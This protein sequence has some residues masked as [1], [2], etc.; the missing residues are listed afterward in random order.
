MTKKTSEGAVPVQEIQTPTVIPVRHFMR[1]AFLLGLVLICIVVGI[2]FHRLNNPIYPNQAVSQVQGSKP[3]SVPVKKSEKPVRVKL[4]RPIREASMIDELPPTQPADP[5]INRSPATIEPL[6][7]AI[8]TVQSKNEAPLSLI[9]ALQLRDKLAM[10][11]SC[12][13]DVESLLNA[14]TATAQPLLEKLIPVCVQNDFWKTLEKTFQRDKQEA[15][16]TYY[17]LN[18]PMWLAYIKSFL[19]RMIDI[20]RIHPTK[21]RP[22][23][24]LA[25]AQEAMIQHR[26]DAVIANIQKLPPVLQAHFR[27]FLKQ[28]QTYLAAQETVE[29]IILSFDEGRK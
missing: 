21:M 10:G 28:A 8:A 18:N 26:L 11:E 24:F 12:Q 29:K 19:V 16:I 6:N 20:Q 13:Q 2:L 1:S 27:D 7:H 14:P 3:I 15:L 22:K 4:P 23:D 17:H 9:T 5:I 25:Q